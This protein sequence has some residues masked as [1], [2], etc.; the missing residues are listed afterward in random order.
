MGAKFDAWDEYFNFSHWSEA[1]EE[2]NIDIGFYVN[3]RPASDEIFAWDFIS[4]GES[5]KALFSEFRA[6]GLK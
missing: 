5:K 3:R 4:T 2:S 1:S 6:A